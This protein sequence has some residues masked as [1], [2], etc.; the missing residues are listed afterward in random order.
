MLLFLALAVLALFTY[1]KVRGSIDWKA[2]VKALKSYAWEVRFTK[3]YSALYFLAVWLLAINVIPFVISL[4][5][6]P[7]YFERYPIAGSVA[8]YLIVAKGITH[9]NYR[10]A[11][12]A[13]VIIII[14]LSAANLQ[15]YYTTPT[16]PQ[17][18]EAIGFINENAK[19]GDLVL[20]YPFN[21][22][23]LYDY[24]GFVAGVNT[25]QFFLRKASQAT[26]KNYNQI[27]TA[28]IAYGLWITRYGASWY[29]HL[30]HRFSIRPY[31]PLTRHITRPIIRA[32]TATTFICLKSEHEASRIRTYARDWH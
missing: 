5:S 12:L 4:F 2:P 22:T 25:T 3:D 23:V 10:Y 7:I 18:R 11:K 27:S 24:Y 28:I 16:K 13:V 15:T 17:A 29:Y 1:H 9:I 26:S 30:I 20:L 32:I 21:N 8:L 31:K 14:A 19:N 6:R